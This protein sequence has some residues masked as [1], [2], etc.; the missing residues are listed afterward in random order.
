[1]KSLL[2]CLLLGT[3]SAAQ[4]IAPPYH[5]GY[6]VGHTA[7]AEPPL[8]ALLSHLRILYQ[9]GKG[10]LSGQDG[11]DETYPVADIYTR[12]YP[13]DYPE[14][15]CHADYPA[16]SPFSLEDPP[17]CMKLHSRRILKTDSGRRHLLLLTGDTFI[18][19]H[20]MKGRATLY[21]YDENR[22][23]PARDILRGYRSTLIGNFGEAPKNWRWLE[24]G[25][26]R[27]GVV[28]LDYDVHTGDEDARYIILRPDDN[29][30]MVDMVEH[31]LIDRI[32]ALRDNSGAYGDCEEEEDVFG[33]TRAQCLSGRIS[34]HSILNVRKNLAPNA[35]YYPL[36]IHIFDPKGLDKPDKNTFILPY[37]PDKA[38]WEIPPDY[39]I[40]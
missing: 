16:D 4:T 31:V 11:D 13:Y 8:T 27:W 38:T 25:P 21:I 29:D 39:P 32:P 19:V 35:G 17:H 28:G 14:K 22:Q 9:Q 5:P 7:S 30:D 12:Y 15:T 20:P 36:E 26:G 40:R 10:A 34:R 23:D 6:P 3:V 18:S 37:N 33:R 2:S 1:M 24:L